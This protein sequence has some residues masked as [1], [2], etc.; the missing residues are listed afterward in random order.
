ML[1]FLWALG[2]VPNFVAM[3]VG[4]YFIAILEYI[5]IADTFIDLNSLFIALGIGLTF[6]LTYMIAKFGMFLHSKM[7]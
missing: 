1:G 4:D 7:K 6:D 2:E 5:T 3:G